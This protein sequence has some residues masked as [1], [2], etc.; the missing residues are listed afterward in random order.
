[1]ASDFLP[2][3]SILFIPNA[4]NKN[5]WSV[6]INHVRL[7]SYFELDKTRTIAQKDTTESIQM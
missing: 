5:Q 4:P 2:K 6:A 7:L 1:M 3:K